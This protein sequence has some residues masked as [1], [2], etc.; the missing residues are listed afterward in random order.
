MRMREL[1]LRQLVSY[2]HSSADPFVGAGR[3]CR[4]KENLLALC[5]SSPLTLSLTV[6]DRDRMHP[7]FA[8]Y[9]ELLSFVVL[10]QKFVV[11]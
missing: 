11:N 4:P 3:E 5:T 1:E 6:T 2:S 10:V 9:L 7:L 8:D